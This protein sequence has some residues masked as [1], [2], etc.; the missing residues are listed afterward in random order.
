MEEFANFDFN[1]WRKRY[2]QWI[3]HLK[4]RILDVFRSIDRDQD[5]RISQ[6]EFV[7]Y[8]L[9]SSKSHQL[10]IPSAL[11][12]VFHILSVS[13]KP[14]LQQAI[15]STQFIILSPVEF[16]T[17]SLEMNAVANIF[18]MNS[19]GFIDYYEFVSALHPSRDPY[20]KTLDADQINEEVGTVCV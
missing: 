20:R 6:K 10:W 4:S 5:G 13:T 15:S 16:P 11:W 14:Q 2:I 3:S 9:A 17:N 18:D 19:D 7:D 1:I 8:V 12:P